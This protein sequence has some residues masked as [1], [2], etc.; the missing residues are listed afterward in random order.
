MGIINLFTQRSFRVSLPI[1][2][3]GNSGL[4]YFI[5][6]VHV[7][8]FWQIQFYNWSTVFSN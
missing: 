6:R 8:D 4:L 2:K 3:L 7:T 5:V 1:Q